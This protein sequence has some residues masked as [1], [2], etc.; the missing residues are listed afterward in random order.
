MPILSSTPFL[1]LS[2]R[3]NLGQMKFNNGLFWIRTEVG[4][5]VLCVRVFGAP[6]FDFTIDIAEWRSLRRMTCRKV[7]YPTSLVFYPFDWISCLTHSKWSISTWYAFHWN[8]CDL[9]VEVQL[10]GMFKK[11]CMLGS[12]WYYVCKDLNGICMRFWNK[13]RVA[14]CRFWVRLHFQSSVR[15]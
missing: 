9:K 6:L 5:P 2:A 7:F 14:R 12:W 10:Q 15:D 13:N 1:G 4:L 11:F 3:L 8:V